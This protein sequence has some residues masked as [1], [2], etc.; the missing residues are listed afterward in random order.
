MIKVHSRCGFV[1]L[2]GCD[3][4]PVFARISIRAFPYLNLCDDMGVL[5]LAW[6][7]RNGK[8]LTSLSRPAVAKIDPSA[9]HAQSH[10]ILA[11]AFSEAQGTYPPNSVRSIIHVSHYS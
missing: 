1:K 4:F 10:M 2:D 8:P 5:V 7:V 6:A 9:D 3:G 11:C